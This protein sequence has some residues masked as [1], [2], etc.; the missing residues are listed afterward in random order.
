MVVG[1]ERPGPH[2]KNVRHHNGRN[3]HSD[4]RRGGIEEIEALA[5]NEEHSLKS[6]YVRAMEHLL[7]LQYRGLGETENVAGWKN[8]VDNARANWRY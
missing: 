4:N 2:R 6:Q 5:R 8:S 1:L 3:C 7:K